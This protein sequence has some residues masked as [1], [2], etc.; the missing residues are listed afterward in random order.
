MCWWLEDRIVRVTN[1]HSHVRLSRPLSVVG[2]RLVY[3]W[4]VSGAGANCLFLRLPSSV[5]PL[6]FSSL[7]S[8]RL[9]CCS[10][11]L[12]ASAVAQQYSPICRRGFGLLVGSHCW[13]RLRLRQMGG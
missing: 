13:L 2:C 11:M 9:L 5:R 4:L 10:A 1:A 6:L 8:Q 3:V 7:N 12:G